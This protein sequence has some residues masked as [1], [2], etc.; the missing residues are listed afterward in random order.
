MLRRGQGRRSGSESVGRWPRSRGCRGD[1]PSWAPCPD[2]WWSLL[3]RAW[4][5]PGRWVIRGG[6]SCGDWVAFWSDVVASSNELG[7]VS[8]HLGL[9]GL[10]TERQRVL[11]VRPVPL[12]RGGLAE[13]AVHVPIAA[14]S[15]WERED[16]GGALAGDGHGAERRKP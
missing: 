5:A 13:H 14:L 3:L 4:E 6:R 7:L 2:C 15:E 16:R 11:S 9:C 10:A 12:L 8:E 1:A